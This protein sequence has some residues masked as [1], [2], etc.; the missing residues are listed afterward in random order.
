MLTE[1]QITNRYNTL[2]QRKTDLK[3][4]YEIEVN[5]SKKKLIRARVFEITIK[6]ILLRQILEL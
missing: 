6:L 5:T 3:E 2:T 4:M 1:A